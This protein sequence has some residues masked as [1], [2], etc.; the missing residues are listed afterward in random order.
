VCDAIYP[1]YQLLLTLAADADHYYLDDTT[2]RILDA[3]PIE[4]KVRN[5]DKTQL[6]TAVY[7]IRRHRHHQ[8]GTVNRLV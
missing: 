1:V 7:N 5:S 3:R 2:H 6:R 4:K 8:G